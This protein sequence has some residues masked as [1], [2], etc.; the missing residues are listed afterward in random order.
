MGLPLQ[1]TKSSTL[2]F[3]NG[4]YS[5]QCSAIDWLFGDNRF[6]VSFKSSRIV[7]IESVINEPALLQC[8]QFLNG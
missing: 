8:D 4:L 6:T 1:A 3:I 2:L 7:L 5:A